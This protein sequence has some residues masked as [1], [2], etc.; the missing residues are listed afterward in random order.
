MTFRETDVLRGWCDNDACDDMRLMKFASDE[1]SIFA[2]NA[3]PDRFQ[4]VASIVLPPPTNMEKISS[5]GFAAPI[6]QQDDHPGDAYEAFHRT[7]DVTMRGCFVN[8]EITWGSAHYRNGMSYSGMFAGGVPHGFGEKRSGNSVYKGRFSEGKRHGRGALFDAIHHRLCLGTF[9]N[10]VPAG[11]MIC[12]LFSWSEK[13]SHVTYD[14][15][16]LTFS[17]GQLVCIEKRIDGRVEDFSGLSYDEFLDVF[18]QAERNV[19]GAVSR[20]R[21]QDEG[22]PEILWK[23][24]RRM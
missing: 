20:K 17:N 5:V 14:R 16:L 13:N 8:G 6:L 12:L 18:K 3:L 19:R 9:E 11:K 21:L 7:S 2:T 24:T 1:T 22:A 23:K 10:D 4:V 15:S